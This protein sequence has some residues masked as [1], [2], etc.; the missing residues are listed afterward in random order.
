MASKKETAAPKKDAA[1]PGDSI[2][3]Y[4]SKETRL[5]AAAYVSSIGTDKVHCFSNE[6][7]SFSQASRHATSLT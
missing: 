4:D 5:L 1:G 7:L 3:G 2:T 6:T